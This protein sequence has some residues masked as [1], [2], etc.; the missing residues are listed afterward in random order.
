MKFIRINNTI[1]NT[2][3]VRDMELTGDGGLWVHYSIK[4]MPTT[5]VNLGTEDR[6]VAKA[7]FEEVLKLLNAE[8]KD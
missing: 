8:K 3:I 1:I 5:R 2:T 4:D 6:E 7:M